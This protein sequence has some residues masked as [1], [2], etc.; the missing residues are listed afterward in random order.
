[1][2]ISMEIPIIAASVV[3]LLSG[4]YYKR[5]IGGITGDCFGATIQ[6]TLIAIYLCGVWH[7]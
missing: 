2:R 6:L 4:I 3:T 5:R 7:G 1:M